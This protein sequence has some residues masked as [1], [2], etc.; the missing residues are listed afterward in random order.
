[1]AQPITPFLWF[2]SEALE[3]AEHYTSIFP[4]S[5]I[6]T[7]THYK[8]AGPG[9]AGR[10]MTVA[11]ELNGQSLVALNG[12]PQY[13]FTEALSLLI[14]C[15]DQAEIDYYWERLTDGGEEG[16]CGWLKDR[17]GLS[18]QVAPRNFEEIVGDADPEGARRAMEA[19]FTMHKL[20]IAVLK[21]A[22]AGVAA[23]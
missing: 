13:R 5:R 18:W 17:Y 9:P 15:E 10:V 11:F 4:N 22:A 21:D 20:D 16:P 6:T 2:D 8:E 14:P 1:M 23:A 7:V 12:G 19:M 3:A